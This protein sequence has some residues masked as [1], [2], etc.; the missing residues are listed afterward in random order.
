MSLRQTDGRGGGARSVHRRAGA[1]F[2]LIELLVV[3]GII[4]LLMGILLPSLSGAREAARSAACLSNQRQIAIAMGQYVNEYKEIMP[5]EGT[6]DPIFEREYLSWAVALRPFLDSRVSANQD[7][8][9]LFEVAPYYIDPSRPKD[10]HRIH[11][12]VN[13]VPFLGPGQV[14]PAPVLFG[15]HWYRRGPTHIS[16]LHFPEQT[17]YTGEFG[18]DANG[19]LMNFVNACGPRDIEKAQVYDLWS[20]EAIVEGVL[21]RVSTK[22]HMGSGNLAYMDGHAKS[23]KAR[24]I[25]DVNTWD[26]RD[27][28]SRR[29]N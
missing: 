21:Q 18:D 26:D 17:C 9:D 16:R 1:G 14:D 8:D 13:A 29:R 25:A 23:V 6:V 12:I 24:E 27:Y 5:R 19:Q 11:Y 20:R 3:I 15:D 7:L 4:A 28:G 10:G 2:T 22:R